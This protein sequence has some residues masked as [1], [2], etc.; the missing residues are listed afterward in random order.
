MEKVKIIRTVV[1]PCEKPA[2]IV[3]RPES[4]TTRIKRLVVSPSDKYHVDS[5]TLHET[6]DYL[7]SFKEVEA[8]CFMSGHREDPHI[9]LEEVFK[10]NMNNQTQ[11]SA[12][13]DRM[14]I[15]LIFHEM[16]VTGKAFVGAAH[17]HPGTGPGCTN[18]S[19]IDLKTHSNYE[20]GGYKAIGMIFSRD[21]YLRFYTYKN[22]FEVYINGDF[23][24]TFD[25]EE[26]I[27]KLS[28]ARMV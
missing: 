20:Q 14:S 11:I 10:P 28:K 27:Y 16:D 6:F 5:D 22:P 26:H 18:P 12:S 13:A 1:E 7:K 2:P 3:V 17:M 8:L 24:E 9:Y 4:I 25:E 15:Y 23:I 19:S 21:G